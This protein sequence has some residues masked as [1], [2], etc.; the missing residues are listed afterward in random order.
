[1]ITVSDRAILQIK[2]SLKDRGEGI[3]IRFGTKKAGCSGLS[4]TLE[5]LD[6]CLRGCNIIEKEG[7]YIGIDFDSLVYLKGTH[8]DYVREGLNEGFE[9]TNPNQSGKCGCGETFSV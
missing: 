5:Y 7:V 9:F 1:M 4:Y 8:I 3:G 2:K 6:S